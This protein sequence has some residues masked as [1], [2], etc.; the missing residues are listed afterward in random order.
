MS[1]V[2][3][4]LTAESEEALA[5]QIATEKKGSSMYGPLVIDE[6]KAPVIPATSI[7]SDY[8]LSELI[9]AI[10]ADPQLAAELVMAELTRPQGARKG[11]LQYFAKQ[12]NLT[13]DLAKLVEDALAVFD[14]D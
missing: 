7:G 9:A 14:K 1:P 12:E 3:G 8:T 4:K 11:A 13:P 5:S 10:D 2:Y 6:A